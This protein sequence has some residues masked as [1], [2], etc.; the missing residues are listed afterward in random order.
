[1]GKN[2]N[3]NVLRRIFCAAIAIAVL[4]NIYAVSAS[5]AEESTVQAVTTGTKGIVYGPSSIVDPVTPEKVTE[6]LRIPVTDELAE[7]GDISEPLSRIEPAADEAGG[8]FA[9][10]EDGENYDLILAVRRKSKILSSEIIGIEKGFNYYIPLQAFSNIVKFPSQTNLAAG[11]ISG[12]FFDPQ[13]TYSVDTGRGIFTVRGDR[14]DLPEGS[15]IVRDLGQNI[16][17]IYVTLEV[18]NKIWPLDAELEFSDLSINIKTKKLLPYEREAERKKKQ[19]RLEGG[20]EQAGPTFEFLPNRYK[21]LSRPI[22]NVSESIF[23]EEEDARITNNVVVSGRNDL[24]GTSADYTANIVYEKGEQPDLTTLRL[25]MTREDLGDGSLPFGLKIA[26]VGDVSAKPSPLISKFFTG[27]GGY[28]SSS[29]KPKNQAFDEITVEGTAEPGWE[30]E[31]YRSKELLDFGFVDKTG[32]YVFENVPLNYGRN[33]IR[34][35]LYGP[36]GQIEERAKDYFIKKTQLLPGQTDFEASVID[37][38]TPLFDVNNQAPKEDQD[39]TKFLRI[40]R[41]INHWLTGFATFTQTPAPSTGENQEFVTLGGNFNALGGAGQ[42]EVYKQLDG[43]TVLD[44]RFGTQFAGINTSFRTS[45]LKD[46]ESREAGT[47]Q[48]AK[49]FEG[50]FRANKSFELESGRLGFNVNTRHTKR[51]DS[52]STTQSRAAQS[53][54]TDKYSLSNSFSTIHNNNKH[55]STDGTLALNVPLS[56]KWKTRAALEYDVYPKSGL[57]LSRF[58]LSY[59]DLDK[60]TASANVRQGIDDSRETEI[61]ATATYD[62]DTFLGSADVDWDRQDGL[63][64]LLH[65]ST[66]LGPDGE[67]NSYIATTDYKGH[68]TALKMRLFHDKN[69]DGDFGGDDEPV[70]GGKVFIGGRRS[71]ASDSEGYIEL[72]G[73]GPPGLVDITVDQ[74]SLPNP[75]LIP[76]K[77]G[78]STVLRPRTKPYI[79]FALIESGGIDGTIRFADGRPIPGLIVQLL[80]HDGV[81]L[82]EAT[83]LS[84]GFY[85]FEFV[86]PGTYTVQVSPSHEINVPPMTVSVTSEEIFAYGVD[87]ILLE[88]AAEV[89]AADEADGE[90]GRVAQLHHAPVADGTLQPAPYSSDGG[91]QAVVRSVRIGEHP[92]KVRLVMDLSGPTGYKISSE[93]GGEVINIDLP[94][95]AWDAE[96][97][98][99]LSKH[100]IFS[101]CEVQGLDGGS[102]TRLRLTARSPVEIFYNATL[103]PAEGRPDRIYVDFLKRSAPK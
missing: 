67:N 61:G 28:L 44:T 71:K 97:Y 25:R 35:V 54:S 87:L 85:V 62:F 16:G 90:S 101:D 100:P 31:L 88:Q 46:F 63:D 98:H 9:F 10:P 68:T 78:Y 37:V 56:R 102:G 33:E 96:R 32:Q 86:K 60:F 52:R 22:L 14:F 80:S 19:A 26:Q 92:Y 12:S 89:S 59:S 84:D 83:T 17:E 47:G 21:L 38:G 34:V 41:G 30:I 48:N 18:L 74:E 36:Q 1:M 40:N 20:E 99:D 51:K 24:L 72:L 69:S 66:T 5:A 75:F 53:F 7:A 103:P 4:A 95:T 70:E 64:V 57:D 65:A 73:A 94:S 50:E 42:I 3:G 49:I 23:W 2:H 8:A 91:F 81:V 55:S 58:D 93:N 6:P 79:E 77:D 15:Y 43:G 29:S 45:F 13:N 82:K 11:T 39:S 76:I 27:R